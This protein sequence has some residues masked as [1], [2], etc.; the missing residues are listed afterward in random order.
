[1]TGTNQIYAKQFKHFQNPRCNSVYNRAQASSP[2][3]D[4]LLG[5]RLDKILKEKLNTSTEKFVTSLK[6]W[7]NKTGSLTQSQFDSFQK[8]ESRF[9]PAEKLKLQ[10]WTAEYLEKHLSEAK[11]LA[12]Y[13]LNAGYW[14]DMAANILNSEDYVPPRHKYFKMSTNKYALRVLENYRNAP[15][16]EKGSMVQLRSTVGDH[17]IYI[18][19]RKFRSRLGFVLD[20]S[21]DTLSATKGGKGYTILPMGHHEPIRLEERHLMKPNKKGKSV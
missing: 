17:S 18:Y 15:K 9:S 8:I 4:P 10:D 19:L 16:F 1:M 7:F 20:H 12:S 11:I 2:V 13:Y 21:S 3:V 6:E 5:D 14:T